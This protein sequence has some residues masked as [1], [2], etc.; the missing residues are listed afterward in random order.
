MSLQ[1][2]LEG[3]EIARGTLTEHEHSCISL[4]VASSMKTSSVRGWP[5][6]FAHR[7]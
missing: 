3:F 4:P 6:E 1:V 2:A 5:L 7:I